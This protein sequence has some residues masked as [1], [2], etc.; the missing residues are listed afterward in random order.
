VAP[1]PAVTP[2]TT[3][4]IADVLMW[5]H[6]DFFITLGALLASLAQIVAVLRTLWAVTKGRGQ[7]AQLIEMQ[8]LAFDRQ[9]VILRHLGLSDA[10]VAGWAP[11]P[12]EQKG[13]TM[14]ETRHG[15]PDHPHGGPP[16][17]G[18]P[19]VCGPPEG[20]LDV[21]EPGDPGAPEHMPPPPPAA[22]G[23]PPNVLVIFGDD[24]G[25]SNISAYNLGMMGYRTPNID[26]LAREGILFTDAYAD[27]SCTA[28]RSSFLLGQS[29]LRTGLTKVGLPGD[30]FG[31]SLRDPTLAALLRDQ[32]YAT[33]HFGKNHLGDRDWHL[34]TMHGF[35]VFF[36][37]LYHLNAEEE[38]E[39]PDFPADPRYP[40]PRGVLR[41]Q[42]TPDGQVIED[43]GPLT[44]ARMPGIDDEF[45]GAAADW[46]TAQTDAGHPWFCWM[47]TSRMHVWTRLK[48]ESQ[49]VTGLGLYPDGMTEHDQLVGQLLNLLDELGVADD[50]IVIYSTDNGAEVMTWPD[51]GCAP[52]RGEKNSPWEGGYRVPMLA[53]W[54]GR[55]PSGS[56]CNGITSMLDWLP[57]LWAAVTG[58]DD[59]KRDLLVGKIIDGKPYR[60]HLDGYNLLDALMGRRVPWPRRE[61]FYITDDGRLAALRFNQWKFGFLELHDQG[62]RT[63]ISEFTKARIPIITNLRSDPFEHAP[64]EPAIGWQEWMIR[65]FYLLAGAGA[66]VLAL[67]ASFAEFPSRAEDPAGFAAEAG[68][69]SPGTLTAAEVSPVLA[70]WQ[71]GQGT[72]EQLAAFLSSNPAAD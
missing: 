32:G 13:T 69:E 10:D 21:P 12:A 48:A 55:F 54:P 66:Q 61:F 63:W 17:H 15:K 58:R 40:R 52:F 47:N 23:R 53:R 56:Q 51:G 22:D 24:I 11:P 38:P 29:P 31:I 41:C 42:A 44:I 2:G 14:S 68:L 1:G 49:G 60:V 26:R 5:A 50:T 71:G 3:T 57:T 35:D 8:R 72:L 59:L 33:G 30:L 39:D 34:P 70:V 37:N 9:G 25:W 20:G 62:F 27:Q 28:G 7:Q 16:G 19:P 18:K 67:A 6:L 65:H 64:E 46:I 4:P 45:A 36:G 43:T